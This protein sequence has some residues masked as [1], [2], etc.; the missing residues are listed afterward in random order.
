MG[1]PS[2]SLQTKASIKR[3]PENGTAQD[4]FTIGTS[5]PSITKTLKSLECPDDTIVDSTL[6]SSIIEFRN[7]VTLEVQVNCSSV[8]A[9]IFQLTDD[10]M[11]NLA[12]ALP[13]LESLRL[14]KPCIF[15][16]CKTTVA[17]TTVK[18]HEKTPVFTRG[19]GYETER[20]QMISQK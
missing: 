11:E 12:I 20:K 7:L 17:A 6:V 8:G 9:C 18:V 16:T 5:H 4:G 1:A 19:I 10:D 2:W 14:G 13:H 3:T 15:D